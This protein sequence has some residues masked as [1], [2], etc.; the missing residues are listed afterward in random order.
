MRTI[1]LAVLVLPLLAVV[2]PAHAECPAKTADIKGTADM[3]ACFDAL[4]QA[5][6]HLATL[7]IAL[8]KRLA[9]L[10]AKQAATDTRVAALPG[11]L[12]VELR[13]NF[14]SPAQCFPG[15]LLVGGACWLEGG[16]GV[17]QNAGISY[18]PVHY[19]TNPRVYN[20]TWTSQAGPF[21]PHMVAACL[22][23]QP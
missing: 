21:R 12:K 15:E 5:Q 20:C 6:A 4:N 7:Q 23:K 3:Q 17:L 18:D 13:D 22:T 14:G 10:D 11:G 1:F 16:S 8:E 9:D 2:M 19:P